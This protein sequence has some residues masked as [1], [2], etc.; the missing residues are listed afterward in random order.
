MRRAV[1]ALTLTLAVATPLGVSACGGART[2]VTPVLPRQEQPG[3]LEASVALPARTTLNIGGKQLRG[4]ATLT[5][6]LPAASASVGETVTA[7]VTY[8]NPSTS[9]A[10]IEAPGGSFYNV[11]VTSADGRV[12]FDSWPYPVG[13]KLPAKIEQLPQGETMSGTVNFSLK[14]PGTYG[15]VAYLNGPTTPPVTLT[16]SQ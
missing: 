16:V 5:L 12:V 7:S 11:R 14:N 4:G 6:R 15:V 2:S 3:S 9:T 1:L 10:V 13:A 8:S